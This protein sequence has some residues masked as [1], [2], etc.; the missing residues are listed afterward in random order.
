MASSSS[1]SGSVVN[2]GIV[3]C[4][5]ISQRRHI[6]DL[7]QNAQAK[8]VAFCDPVEERAKQCSAK[9]GSGA[10]YNQ[11]ELML[12]HPGLDAV[13]VGTPNYLHAVQSIASLRA[14]KH[15]LV[16]KPMATT[17]DEARA[18]MKAADEAGKFLMVGQNQRLDA[19]HQKARQILAE[20]KIGKVLTFRT[21]FKHRGPDFWSIDPGPG[22]WFFKKSQAVIGVCGDLGIHKADLMRYLLADE[23]AEVSAMITTQDKR[24]ADGSLIDVDDNAMLLVRTASGATGSI[25][26]S[27]T[28]YGEWEANYTLIYG[29]KG[30]MM[31]AT[32]PQWGVIVRYAD[33]TEDRHKTGAMSTNEKQVRSGVSDMFV[34]SILSN[35]KPPI[36]GIEGYK[37]LDVILAAFESSASG[38]TIKLGQ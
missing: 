4:G 10:V 19:A 9:Y 14:G 7:T 34:N 13:V 32:D 25:I 1:S 17:R 12:K 21:A 31:L 11:L 5:A 18:M 35:T 36:D 6:P 33:G 8:I 28:N 3:G 24:Y 29:T 37:S 27:W 22:T 16:E 38:K 26:I 23:I 30:V 2:V 15:V 20:G